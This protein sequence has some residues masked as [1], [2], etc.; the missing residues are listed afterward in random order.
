MKEGLQLGLYRIAVSFSFGV[1]VFLPRSSTAA[2]F[3]SPSGL[4]SWWTLDG[5]FSDRSGLNSAVAQGSPIFANGL[6]AEA[7]QLDDVDDEVSVP[8]GPAQIG[9]ASCRERVESAVVAVSLER[10]E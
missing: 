7:L 9:R 3:P 6:V 8:A 1:L 2:C 10:K 4:V 5:D